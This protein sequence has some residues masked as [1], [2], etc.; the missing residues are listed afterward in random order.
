MSTMRRRRRT[1]AATALLMSVLVVSGCSSSGGLRA[2][3]EREAAARAAAGSAGTPPLDV[4]L[5]THSAEGDTFWDVVR[6]GAEQAAAKDNIDLTYAASPEGGEQAELV[7]QAVDRGVDGIVTT[8]A[9]PDAMRAAVQEATAAGIPVVVV[10]GGADVYAEMGAIAEFGQD[11][12]VAGQEAGRQL[13]ALGAAHAVC[14]VHE[15]GSASLDARCRGAQDTFSG[16]LED[17]FVDISNIPEVTSAVSGK[18]AAD[19]SVDAVLTL[20]APIAN[21]AEQGISDAG[22]SAQLGTFDLDTGLLDALD[23]GTVAFAID[24]QPYLQGYLGVDQVWLSVFSGAVVGG[25]QDVLTG[26][27]VITAE[28]SAAVREAVEA[29]RR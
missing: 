6:A 28:N 18:L 23:A 16:E 11:E 20:A 25:G 27:Q 2:E 29:G 10:N 9:K 17:L 24:Q 1:V 12:F 21:A 14:V 3:Q 5:I 8:L 4:A 7:R 15:Q 19:P 22:S 26:P 13:D